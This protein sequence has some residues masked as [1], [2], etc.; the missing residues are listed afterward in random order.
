[1]P[2]VT[3]LSLPDLLL[4]GARGERIFAKLALEHRQLLIRRVAE[5]P[6]RGFLS[7]RIG[8]LRVD[9]QK[10]APGRLGVAL[11]PSSLVAL[12][13]H[14]PNAKVRSRK[15][16]PGFVT[17]TPDAATCAWPR[18]CIWASAEARDVCT[19]SS[20]VARG[21][22]GMSPVDPGIRRWS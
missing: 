1:M 22:P 7:A 4:A 9:I 8:R 19:R 21:A 5:S 11:H 15:R 13:A 6:E 14:V 2:R 16:A 20:R 3:A 12:V 10:G 18:P 17:S